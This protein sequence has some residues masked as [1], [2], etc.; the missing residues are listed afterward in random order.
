MTSVFQAEVF[1][2]GQAAHHIRT[3]KELGEGIDQIDIITDSKSALNALDG[4]T[5]ALKLVKDCMAELDNLQKE[6]KVK[7]HWIKAHVGH[8]GN[9]KADDLAKQGTKKSS[10][11][12][13]PILPVSKSWTSRKIK[14][15]INNEWINRWNSI[16]EARQTKIF[17]PKPNAKLANKLLSYDKQTCAKLFRWILG[18]SFHNYHN[19]LLHPERSTGPYCRA[20]NLEKEE[21]SHLFAY[22]EALSQI[23]M[24][25]IGN[26]VLPEQFT[27]TPH[28]LLTMIREIDKICPE[29]EI[30]NSQTQNTPASIVNTSHE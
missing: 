3:N 27:W 4:I 24:K 10:H 14:E 19:H 5:T 30:H 29:I 7:V 26:V 15:Y 11:V 13:E 18:H 1:A 9:E 22:C 6:Y 2:I 12:V 16:S 21:T 8:Q 28:Q 23:R 20:C 17:L 25:V